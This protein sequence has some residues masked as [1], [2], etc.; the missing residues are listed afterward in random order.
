MVDLRSDLLESRAQ[1]ASLQKE[2][3]TLLTQLHASQSQS[4]LEGPDV[5]SDSALSKLASCVISKVMI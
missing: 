1:N 2:L 4:K 3:Q 5:N